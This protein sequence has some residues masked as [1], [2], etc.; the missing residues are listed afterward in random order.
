MNREART[1]GSYLNRENLSVTWPVYRRG[2]LRQAFTVTRRAKVRATASKEA[3]TE[4][5]I[6]V[7][8]LAL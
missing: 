7:K 6:F 1:C 4:P 5:G 3:A 8:P 2:T